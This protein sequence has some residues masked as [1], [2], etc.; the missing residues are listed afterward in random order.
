MAV[1]DKALVRLRGVTLLERTIERAAPQVGELLLNANGDPA[2]FAG[3]GLPVIADEIEGFLGPLVGILTGLDWMKANR[4]ETNWL[5]SFACDTPF[6]PDDVVSRLIEKAENASSLVAIA[7]SLGCRHPTFAVWSSKIEETAQ[8]VLV[9]RE[10]RK[11]DDFVESLPYASVKFAARPFDPFFNVNTLE[12][13]S[14]AEAL[15]GAS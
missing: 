13:L 4:P 11:M 6:F 8:S 1:D 15:M 3:F 14:R 5:A 12:D 7:E 10:F 2:R 9:E